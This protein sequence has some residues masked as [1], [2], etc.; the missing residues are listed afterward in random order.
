TLFCNTAIR[1]EY[2][3]K[4]SKCS[5]CKVFSHVL[6]GCPKKIVS[7]VVK[8]LKVSRQ[9]A[10]GPPVDLKPMSTLFTFGFY[11]KG[12]KGYWKSKES[13]MLE[14]KPVLIG[15]DEEPVKQHISVPSTS[16]MGDQGE[17]L[18]DEVED[19]DDDTT[20]FM[21]LMIELIGEA[22]DAGI[23]EDEEFDVYD[24]YDDQAFDLFDEHSFL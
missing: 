23:R 1:V 3:W 5:S 14:G 7:D 22:N 11:Q 2:E 4:P 10:R 17:D 8:N 16:S 19:I 12:G 24:G 9:A 13:Q 21:S 18:E 6:D 15:D 20:R